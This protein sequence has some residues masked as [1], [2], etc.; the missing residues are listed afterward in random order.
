MRVWAALPLTLICWLQSCSAQPRIIGGLAA[1]IENFPFFALL[2]IKK[3]F[4]EAIAPWISYCGGSVL[5]DRWIMTAAHCLE[6]DIP[7]PNADEMTVSVVVGVD[8]RKIDNFDQLKR[9][10][11]SN[12]THEEFNSTGELNNDIALIKLQE[13]IKF[14]EKVATIGLPRK[15]HEEL[16][17]TKGTI[18]G[19]GKTENGAEDWSEKLMVAQINLFHD[20]KYCISKQAKYDSENMFCAGVRDGGKDIC[21]GDSGGPL[22]VERADGSK[23]VAGI[24]SFGPEGCGGIDEP[25]EYVRVS[26]YLDWI[27]NIMDKK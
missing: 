26:V 25:S 17:Y 4:N 12:F 23:F 22:I 2:E 11:Q 20:E 14:N 3:E 27:K 6:S 8:D 21:E 15:A 13:P 10:V 7:F 1:S 16:E 19:F 9:K 18:I 24:A 5:S